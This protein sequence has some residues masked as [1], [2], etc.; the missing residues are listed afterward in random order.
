MTGPFPNSLVFPSLGDHLR[1][2]G[3]ARDK[4]SR[5]EAFEALAREA[6]EAGAATALL[7]RLLARDANG[8]RF[9]LEVAARLT[10]PLPGALIPELVVLLERVRFPTRLRVAVAAQVIRSVGYSSPLVDRASSFSDRSPVQSNRLHDLQFYF[11]TARWRCL[12]DLTPSAAPCPGAEGRRAG[13]P[14]KNA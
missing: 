3:T 12:N 8:Q 2:I 4:A 10:P 6:E 5:G 9:A 14:G 13:G 7:T 1:R 11:P